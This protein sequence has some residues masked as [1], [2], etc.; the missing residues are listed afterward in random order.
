MNILEVNNLCKIFP[1]RTGPDVYALDSV[2]FSIPEGQAFGL[3]GGSGSGKS[4]LALCILRLLDPSSGNI[5]FM[6]WDWL[7][8]KSKELQLSRRKMQPVFQN[9]D[10][11]L[12]P[13]FSVGQVIE[14]PLVIHQVGN[15]A[16]RREKVE[17]LC[18][19][20]GLEIDDLARLPKELS[21]GQRQRV[22]IARA[23]APAPSLLV[24]DEPVSSLDTAT[25]LQIMRLLEKLKNE[26]C[27]TTLFI[28]HDLA[29]VASFCDAAAV[30]YRGR[31]VEMGGAKELFGNPLHS[32]TR[33]LLASAEGRASASIEGRSEVGSGELAEVEPGHFVK[34]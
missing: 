8:L 16:E 17:E 1:V 30:I 20:V 14:E 7:A 27:L 9:P 22:A 26:L 3:V 19:K 13:L 28:S 15:K 33:A 10:D 31:I 6:E 5:R 29:L 4:T 2:S 23:L 25:Q 18:L 11:S 34:R 24:A 21:G 32:Y 12:N